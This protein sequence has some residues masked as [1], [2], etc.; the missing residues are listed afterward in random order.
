MAAIDTDTM[1]L[2]LLQ[3]VESTQTYNNTQYARSQP[4][5][6]IYGAGASPFGMQ[7]CQDS[8]FKQTT[9]AYQHCLCS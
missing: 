8:S 2:S 7:T 4:Q 3:Y 1:K 9:L 6:C 5:L